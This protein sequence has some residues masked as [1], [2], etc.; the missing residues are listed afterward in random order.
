MK[1]RSRR[2]RPHRQAVIRVGTSGWSYA[3]WRRV[4]YPE[5]LPSGKW[6]QYY[7]RYFDTVEI[8]NTFY[9]L[10]ADPA[11]DKWRQEAPSGFVFAVK[12]NR[13]IT[14]MKKLK[15]VDDSVS[16]F[17]KRLK[18]LKSRLGPILF[19]LPP[20][21]KLDTNRLRAFLAALP[22]RRRYAVEFRNSTWLDDEAIDILKKRQIAFCIHDL[23]DGPCP[24]HVT[25]TFAY[26]RFHGHGA[27]YGGSYPKRV[28]RKNAEEMAD[29]LDSGKDVYAYFN[30]DAFGYALKDAVALRKMVSKLLTG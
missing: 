13:F 3:H 17:L 6:F 29:I 7:C 24:H 16:V 9:N 4:F 22:R 23:L 5:D 26:Y 25:A 28:L 1:K 8:N 10:P 2:S 12:A 11:I 20:G 21:L 14:H 15:D 27:K 18:V 19:Q 30:N